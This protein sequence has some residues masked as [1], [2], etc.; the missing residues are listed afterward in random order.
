MKGHENV[1]RHVEELKEDAELK[2]LEKFD[3]IDWSLVE[4]HQQQYGGDWWVHEYVEMF[5]VSWIIYTYICLI[6]WF[7]AV[8]S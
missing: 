7:G 1:G 6:W 4:N 2:L 3:R 8:V 5:G